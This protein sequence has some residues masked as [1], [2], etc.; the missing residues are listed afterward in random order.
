MPEPVPK[1]TTVFAYSFAQLSGHCDD[2]QTVG[3]HFT[4]DHDLAPPIGCRWVRAASR[5][6]RI[7]FLMLL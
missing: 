5:R 7:L 4:P 2:L 3:F 6:L 1:R